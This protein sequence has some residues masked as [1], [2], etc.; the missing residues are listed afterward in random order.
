M[1]S[2]LGGLNYEYEFQD[3]FEVLKNLEYARLLWR[4]ENYSSMGSVDNKRVVLLPVDNN[5]CSIWILH[6]KTAIW[7]IIKIISC[8]TSIEDVDS[9]TPYFYVFVWR[10]CYIPEEVINITT[11]PILILEGEPNGILTG[12]SQKFIL[13]TWVQ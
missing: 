11:Q 3:I 1:E 13:V 10:S 9:H 6:T 7:Y 4:D 8:N 2:I 5:S 12:E